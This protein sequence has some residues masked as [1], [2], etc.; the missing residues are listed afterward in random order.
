MT[1]SSMTGFARETGRHD[2][3][4]WTWEAKSVN[5]R[6]LDVRVRLPQGYERLEIPA[7]RLAGKRLGRGSV[8]LSL[9][10]DRD[11]EKVELRVNRELLE[12]L[13]AM[14]EEFGDLVDSKPPRL[15]NLWAVRGVLETVEEAE[16]KSEVA[17]LDAALLGSLGDALSELARARDAEGVHL[18]EILSAHL[19]TIESLTASAAGS[20]EAQPAAI[21]ERFDARLEA[22]LDDDSPLP[23]DRL[24]QEIAVLALKAD[25]REEIDRLIAHCVA[26]RELLGEDEPVGR[27]LDFLCQELNREANTVCSKSSSEALTRIGLDLKATIDQF[28][29]QVQNVE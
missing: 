29:E 3:R 11:R 18:D 12:Q 1:L 24:S 28:R 27:R 20:A 14:R 17:D 21:K 7:R 26:A 16:T 5:G 10:L 6:S 8:S 13:L 22:L 9:T 25:V 15:D 4:G 23:E 2:S 19:G